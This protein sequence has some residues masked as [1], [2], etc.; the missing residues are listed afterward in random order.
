MT[1]LRA[2]R[3]ERAFSTPDVVAYAAGLVQSDPHF[4][5]SIAGAGL[6]ELLLHVAKDQRNVVPFPQP[7]S[8]VQP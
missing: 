5:A 4:A 2:Y 6:A 8:T 3:I 1:A 7:D